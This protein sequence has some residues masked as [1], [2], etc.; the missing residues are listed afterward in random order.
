MST[1]ELKR[2]REA[3]VAAELELR[4]IDDERV[5]RAMRRVPREKFVSPELADAAYADAPLPIAAGQTISQ[6]YIVALMAQAAR[7]EPGDR[8]LDVGTGSGYGAAVLAEM[9]AEVYGVER[10]RRLVEDA[11]RQLR[12]AG[13]EVQIRHGDGMKGWPE[14]AP[15][16]AIVVAAAASVIPPDLEQQ[17]AI[18]GRLVI[19]VKRHGGRQVLVRR[20]RRGEDEFEEQ[21]L[22]PVAFVPL[23]AGT[24][25]D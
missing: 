25:Q 15:F 20:V 7:I 18:G 5:L 24:E 22:C 6:P 12:E 2:Q 21:T 3:L 16:D 8:V 11:S 13:Y 19:P 4:D 23:L 10:H 14:K 17:L 1:E 9:G